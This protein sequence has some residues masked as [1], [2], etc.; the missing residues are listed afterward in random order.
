[1]ARA[2]E[3]ASDCCR[4]RRGSR[5]RPAAPGDPRSRAVL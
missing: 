2:R 4:L 3:R 5:R 1:M